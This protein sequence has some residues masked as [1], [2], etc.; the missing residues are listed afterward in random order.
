MK[1]QT[2]I[3]F[4]SSNAWAVAAAVSLQSLL[5]HYEGSEPL[6]IYIVSA[7]MSEA[8]KDRFLSYSGKNVEVDVLEVDASVYDRFAVEGYY[9]PPLALLKFSLSKLLPQ[10]NKILYL[11][12]DILIQKDI[13]ELM[14]VDIEGYYAAGVI[15]MTAME[16]LHW[17]K[18]LNRMRYLNTGVL[19]LNAK[20]IRDEGL[21]ERFFAVKEAHPEYQ[22]MEQDTMNDVFNDEVK[23]LPPIWNLMTYNLWLNPYTQYSMEQI[24]F[25][26]STD[27]KIFEDL[28]REAVIIH[29]T[30]EFKPWEY[31]GA[32]MSDRW[33]ETFR[34]SKFADIPLHLKQIPKSP[35]IV[36]DGNVH[37]LSKIGPFVKDWTNTLTILRFLGI[38]LVH[39]I[40]GG[41]YTSFKILCIPVV[42]R[43]WS[44][45]EEKTYLLG[46]CVRRK[47]HWPAI[48]HRA[49]EIFGS[50]GP[51]LDMMLSDD[52]QEQPNNNCGIRQQ[53]DQLEK[54]RKEHGLLR[55]KGN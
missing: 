14:H 48:K 16:T 12:I 17:H 40:K 21:E 22:C 8:N 33:M 49:D 30:N 51:I 55:L 9:V 3:V 28:E 1:N 44:Q 11:D 15:D 43:V 41:S 38:P 27:Y 31:D 52:G 54:M 13:S 6:K 36:N 4:I 35:A 53:L 24:N 23:Y 5:D 29:L 42:K 32:Y 26:Y 25:F 18:R 37:M 34:R 10:Y 45:F 47:T 39:K 19:L 50:C 7:D 46:I 2:P 20:R